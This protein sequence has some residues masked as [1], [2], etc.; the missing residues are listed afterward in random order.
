MT[1]ILLSLLLATTPA[2]VTPAQ[3]AAPRPMLESC[4]QVPIASDD[5]PRRG[6]DRAWNRLYRAGY[7]E[8][9]RGELDAAEEHLCAA[10]RRA[11]SFEPR[12]WR[13]AETL[14][15]LGLLHHLRGDEEA[16]V[17]AQGAAVAE[18]LLAKGPRAPEVALYVQRLGIP[19]GIAGRD[20]LAKELIAS[21]HRVFAQGWIP[22]D[23]R[24]AD[25]LDWLV[26]EYLRIEDLAA[27]GALQEL[28]DRIATE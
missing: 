6:D 8:L 26:G 15:D 10:L 25:R 12:D 18:M 9:E 2:K 7:E 14:D 5:S 28:V 23:E 3:D 21:P 13:F 22:L 4:L 11:R 16:C 24:L 1:P 19:L 17:R 27:A 20:E